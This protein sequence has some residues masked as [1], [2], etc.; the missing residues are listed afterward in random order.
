[1]KLCTKFKRNEAIR[2][3][4]IANSVSDLMTLNIALRVAHGSGIIFTKCNLRLRQL[5][6]V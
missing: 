2:G 5:I 4:V 3:V 6:H 1:M